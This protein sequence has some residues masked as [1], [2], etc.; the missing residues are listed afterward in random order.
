MHICSFVYIYTYI[1]IYI[2]TPI[3]L[4]PGAVCPGRPLRRRPAAGP[5]P[6][7]QNS[8]Y[9]YM[10]ICIYIYIYIYLVI[11][12]YIHTYKHTYIYI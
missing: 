3:R 5:G 8:M 1:Y 9:I 4:D 6:V 11:H 7:I 10:Y 2:Y 12:T